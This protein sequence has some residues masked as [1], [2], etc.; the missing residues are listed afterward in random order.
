[1]ENDSKVLLN[2]MNQNLIPNSNS[3]NSQS[4]QSINHMNQFMDILKG[5]QLTKQ[6][7]GN[8]LNNQINLNQ[9]LNQNSHS[10]NILLYDNLVQNL[11]N[12]F[13]KK[14][15]RE[16]DFAYNMNTLSNVNNNLS[17]GNNW[18][19]KNSASDLSNS[20]QINNSQNILYNFIQG[21]NIPQNVNESKQI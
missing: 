6:D 3:I 7:F 5:N 13:L 14:R 16:N 8:F 4:G 19:S 1:M 2:I 12:D 11:G 21:N 20:G 17:D 9:S 18:M 15:M 10:N